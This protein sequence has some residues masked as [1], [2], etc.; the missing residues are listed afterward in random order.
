M[1]FVDS[2]LLIA[3]LRPLVRKNPKYNQILL[4]A[5]QQMEELFATHSIVK[6]TIYNLAELYKGAYKSKN[7]ANNLRI[8]EKFLERFEVITPTVESSKE[9]ARVW[10]DLE[11][12]GESIGV[13][14][15]LIASVVMSNEDLLVTRNIDHF[16][17][18]PLLEYVDW[19]I[20]EE[21]NQE[22]E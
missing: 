6:T 22:K 8:V 11:M 10:A 4:R 18:I 21:G 2:D 20:I 17:R 9:F 19:S 3:C 7:V 16:G 12:K 13:M 5:R 1:V 15:I 14:D